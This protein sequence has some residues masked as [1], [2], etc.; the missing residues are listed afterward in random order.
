MLCSFKQRRSQG[1]K[2]AAMSQ[3]I[4]LCRT[5]HSIIYIG[6]FDYA[7]KN[8]SYDTPSNCLGVII[9]FVILLRYNNYRLY[10]NYGKDARRKLPPQRAEQPPQR[11][12]L[13]PPGGKSR[14]TPP[15]A[16]DGGEAD[17]T[18]GARELSGEGDMQAQTSVYV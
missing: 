5:L 3:Q 2:H 17:T 11:A 10:N 15:S 9:E 4:F 8:V 6:C 18:D 13:P 7:H 1:V 14:K 12:E 16:A